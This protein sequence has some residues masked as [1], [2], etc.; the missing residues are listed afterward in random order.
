MSYSVLIAKPIEAYR[1]KH[2]DMSATNCISIETKKKSPVVKVSN[3][4]VVQTIY[5]KSRTGYCKHS[6]LLM[7]VFHVLLQVLVEMKCLESG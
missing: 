5:T 7:E 1:D 6:Q 2:R 3:N 4:N